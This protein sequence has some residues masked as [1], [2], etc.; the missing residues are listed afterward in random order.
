MDINIFLARLE[1]S[2]EELAECFFQGDDAS[3]SVHAFRHLMKI[4]PTREEVRDCGKN[5]D[6]KYVSYCHVND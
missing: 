3:I 1:A 2:P 4:I 5:K 6:I